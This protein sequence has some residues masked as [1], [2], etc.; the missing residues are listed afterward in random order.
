M[1]A[2]EYIRCLVSD[3]KP[4]EHGMT[5]ETWRGKKNH[6]QP[7]CRIYKNS[8]LKFDG[9]VSAVEDI[10][11][12]KQFISMKEDSRQHIKGKI[13]TGKSE[14]LSMRPREIISFT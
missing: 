3:P 9:D 8:I 1:K 6:C 11:E 13:Y 2:T 4:E 10:Y 14:E 7:C 5:F 12:L